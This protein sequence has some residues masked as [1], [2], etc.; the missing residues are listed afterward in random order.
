[1]AAMF[2]TASNS[3]VKLPVW[4]AIGMFCQAVVLVTPAELPPD[5]ASAKLLTVNTPGSEIS[6]QFARLLTVACSARNA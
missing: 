5:E 1:M 3:A 6:A 2:G 4:A